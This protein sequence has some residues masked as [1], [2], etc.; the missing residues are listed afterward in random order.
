VLTVLTSSTNIYVTRLYAWV[1]VSW[2]SFHLIAKMEEGDLQ[3]MF[4]EEYVRY[5]E[6]VP[7]FLGRSHRSKEKKD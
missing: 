7:L 1:F 3:R 5:R 2:I 4:G 6:S